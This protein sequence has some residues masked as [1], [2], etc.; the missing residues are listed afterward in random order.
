MLTFALLWYILLRVIY[1]LSCLHHYLR[2]WLWCIRISLCTVHNCIITPQSI[3]SYT[4]QTKRKPIWF[5]NYFHFSPKQK[6]ISLS[7]VFIEQSYSSNIPKPNAH[8][9]T[10]NRRCVCL[11]QSETETKRS[12]PRRKPS[13]CLPSSSALSS[14]PETISR[15]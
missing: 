1:L 11:H 4:P 8:N 12:Q 9:L 13:L 14:S 7:K 6:L 3:L 15:C 2:G 10:G 5:H